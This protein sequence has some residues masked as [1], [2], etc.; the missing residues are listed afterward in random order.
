MFSVVLAEYES[1]CHNLAYD[2]AL[3]RARPDQATLWLWRNDPCVVLGRGQRAEREVDLTAC[4][5]AGVPVLRRASGGG[6]VYHDRG[7]LN[8]T[9]AALAGSDPLAALGAAL[10]RMVA[11]LGLTP[12]LGKRGLFVGT[13]KLCGFA[14]LRTATGV[15]A[16]STLLCSTPLESVTRYLAD[17]PAD[18][19]PLDSERGPVT[20]L[21]EHGI[22][23]GAEGLV[24]DAVAEQLGT[25]RHRLPI[26][27]ELAQ[28]KRLLHTRYGFGPWHLSG[29]TRTTKEEAWTQRPA[30]ISTG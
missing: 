27:S 5:S 20:S 4:S 12:R 3:V 16:H 14:S 30:S 9:L 2:E 29:T 28:Q 1:S 7:N 18:A 11:R 10:T 21:A 6:T 15:L 13:A 23:A 19:H 24:L 26:G 25:A 8:I 17:S 22:T